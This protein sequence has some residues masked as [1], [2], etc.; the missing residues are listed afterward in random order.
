MKLI[1]RW[2]STVESPFGIDTH[3]EASIE[4]KRVNGKVERRLV[5]YSDPNLLKHIWYNVPIILRRWRMVTIPNL[6][7]RIKWQR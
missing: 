1:R 2:F 6:W 4:V 5:G 3:I 7:R